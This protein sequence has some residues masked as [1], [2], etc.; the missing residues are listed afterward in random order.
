MIRK[1]TTEH[2]L[3]AT[4]CK[5]LVQL[6]AGLVMYHNLAAGDPSLSLKRHCLPSPAIIE[7]VAVALVSLPVQCWRWSAPSALSCLIASLQLYA[8]R[9]M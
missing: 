3:C 5:W 9:S 8:V 7:V 1:G 2:G 4:R 6:K